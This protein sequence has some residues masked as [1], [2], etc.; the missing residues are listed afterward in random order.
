VSRNHAKDRISVA[1]NGEGDNES[2][3]MI[4]RKKMAWSVERAEA[5]EL[6]IEGTE[7]SVRAD[8]ETAS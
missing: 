5:E 4:I 1:S 3:K 7:G 6:G 8:S 2:Q